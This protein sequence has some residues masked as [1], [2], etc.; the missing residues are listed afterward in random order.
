M[1]LYGMIDIAARED[2]RPPS[3]ATSGGRLSPAAVN[4]DR[5][6]SPF[7]TSG[8]RLSSAAVPFEDKP[9]HNGRYTKWKIALIALAGLLY[10]AA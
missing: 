7:A 10:R 5:H 4:S 6:I 3:F 1:N 8:G 2:T 9:L